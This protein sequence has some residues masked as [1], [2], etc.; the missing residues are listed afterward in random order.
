MLCCINREI[1]NLGEKVQISQ[2]QNLVSLDNIKSRNLKKVNK[3]LK[4][5][6]STSVVHLD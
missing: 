4:N 1:Q 6:F 3:F 2:V 5:M